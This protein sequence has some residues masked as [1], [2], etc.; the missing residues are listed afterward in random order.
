MAAAGTLGA[1]GCLWPAATTILLASSPSSS[2]TLRMSATTDAPSLLLSAG[3]NGSTPGPVTSASLRSP[4]FPPAPV[5]STTAALPLASS[6]PPLA[7]PSPLLAVAAPS[8]P[9]PTAL[10]PS[11]GT[12]SGLSGDGGD[13][14]TADDAQCIAEGGGGGGAACIW[15]TST[16]NPTN[17]GPLN[18]L[19]A[20]GGGVAA[21]ADDELDFGSGV[22]EIGL[23]HMASC[24]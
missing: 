18:P 7:P 3:L 8:C 22:W 21:A 2:N 20:C 23:Q 11:G 4:P 1:A 16:G 6:L 24:P 5:A 15:A 9:C 14:S 17:P 10:S 13:N 12:V 19:T